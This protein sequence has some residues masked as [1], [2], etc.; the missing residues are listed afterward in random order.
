M[1]PHLILIERF[2]S[3]VEFGDCWRWVASRNGVGY[4]NMNMGGG[5]WILAHRFAYEF[6]VGPIPQGLQIDHLC[7][8]RHC[9]KPEHLEPVT[10]R[11]NLRRGVGHGNEIHCPHGHPYDDANTYYRKQGGRDCRTCNRLRARRRGEQRVVEQ[12]RGPGR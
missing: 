8:V 5:K 3:R 4:G 12:Q 10:C 2:W 6:C 9:V 11:E 1:A 7:R